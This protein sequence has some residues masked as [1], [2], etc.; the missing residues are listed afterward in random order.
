MSLTVKCH[1]TAKKNKW[2]FL[3]DVLYHESFYKTSCKLL[4]HKAHLIETASLRDS[5]DRWVCESKHRVLEESYL[6]GSLLSLSP[7]SN[8]H[9]PNRFV[10]NEARFCI[11]FRKSQSPAQCSWITSSLQARER[12]HHGINSPAEENKGRVAAPEG[13]LLEHL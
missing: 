13:I 10:L 1:E 11:D 2:C 5:C 3:S 9:Q 6:V 8:L 7:F 12:G 4:N